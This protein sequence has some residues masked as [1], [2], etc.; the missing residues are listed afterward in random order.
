VEIGDDHLLGANLVVVDAGGLDDDEALV[1]IDTGG[2]AKGLQD[3]ASTN[4]FEVG[5][6]DFFAQTLKQHRILLVLIT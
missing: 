2:I 6:K 3:E 5:F 1:A 4:E